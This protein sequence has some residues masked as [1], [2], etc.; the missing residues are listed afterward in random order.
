MS[1]I[2]ILAAAVIALVDNLIEIFRR[3]EDGRQI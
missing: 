1:T 2:L 3:E